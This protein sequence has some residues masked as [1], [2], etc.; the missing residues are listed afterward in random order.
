MAADL[1]FALAKE[2][3]QVVVGEEPLLMSRR[4]HIIINDFS[5][6]FVLIVI[7]MILPSQL[8]SS[9]TS[10]HLCNSGLDSLH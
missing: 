1:V 5:I 3:T 10:L 8:Q 2:V 6:T 9:G 4:N 7:S